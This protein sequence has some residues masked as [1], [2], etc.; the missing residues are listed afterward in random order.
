MR[1]T[2]LKAALAAIVLAAPLAATQASAK[3][4]E[5]KF[6]FVN[7]AYA[8]YPVYE[9]KYQNGKW[10]W[11]NKG[12]AFKPRMKYRIKHNK[13]GVSSHNVSAR[14]FLENVEIGTLSKLKNVKEE[15]VVLNIGSNIMKHK[16]KAARAACN[17]YGGTKKVIKNMGLN[18][19]L[20][21]RHT[22][23]GSHKQTVQR[24]AVMTAKVVCQPRDPKRT[25]HSTVALKLKGVKLYTVP[26]RPKCGKPVK[27]VAEFQTNRPGKVEFLYYRGDGKKQ[28]A[29]VTTSKGGAGFQKHW[30]K[31]YKINKTTSRKY[32][33][34]ALGHKASTPWV[35]LKVN[36]IKGAKN[37]AG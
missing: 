11:A 31:T 34:V 3:I 23:Y 26:A 30:V 19:Q 9:M 8:D 22:N 6:H 12:K 17:A 20:T 25:G 33:V 21:V 13:G 36:C 5:V 15:L 2:I 28:K 29:S 37:F 27:M 4:K 14:F 35:P 24:S 18:G 32:K 1:N 7:D 10:V 16:E